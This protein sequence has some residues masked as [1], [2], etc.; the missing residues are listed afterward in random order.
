MS[1]WYDHYSSKLPRLSD[2]EKQIVEYITGRIPLLL[3]PLF[4]MNKFNEEKFLLS[5]ELRKVY[6]DVSRFFTNRI[7][8]PKKYEVDRYVLF[9]QWFSSTFIQILCHY[10][11]MSSTISCCTKL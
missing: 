9:P 8:A 1:K 3:R 11:S 2:Q 4:D 6:M 10:G 7:D 5:P